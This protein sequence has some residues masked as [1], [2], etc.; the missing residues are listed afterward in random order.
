[1]P[2]VELTHCRERG[3]DELTAWR[4]AM[5]YVRDL[6][7]ASEMDTDNTGMISWPS[8]REAI[9]DFLKSM[10]ADPEVRAATN[11]RFVT[12]SINDKILR[13]FGTTR[14]LAD[15][16]AEVFIAFMDTRLRQK[17][18]A[19]AGVRTPA[20]VLRDAL[21]AMLARN[22]RVAFNILIWHLFEDGANQVA[23]GI[24]AGQGQGARRGQPCGGPRA[25]Q[26][27]SQRHRRRRQGQCRHRLLPHGGR[28]QGCL[29][30]LPLHSF[31]GAGR[32]ARGAPAPYRR[33]GRALRA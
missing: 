7:T 15:Y 32:H 4:R 17:I 20:Q 22:K 10:G 11:V 29:G 19:G 16:H 9:I 12:R 26:G 30:W 6:C 31:R 33:P 24:A 23:D 28:D 14:G 5:R 1:M 2:K 21:D 3:E 27:R 13:Q 18:V 8:N 25:E